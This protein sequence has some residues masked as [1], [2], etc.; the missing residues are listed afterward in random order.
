MP[1]ITWTRTVRSSIFQL[2]LV[3]S[4]LIIKKIKFFSYIYQEI[5]NG[6]V[7]KSYMRKGF[8]IYEEMHKYLAIYERPLVI[9]DFAIA[10]ILVSL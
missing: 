5:Q 8:L 2:I 10:P 3:V 6:A 1:T 7:A 4:A 9:Y